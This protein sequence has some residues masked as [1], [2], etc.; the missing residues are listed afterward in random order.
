[1]GEINEKENSDFFAELN[2]E[3]TKNDEEECLSEFSDISDVSENDSDYIQEKEYDS[4]DSRY[5]SLEEEEEAD[6]L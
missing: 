5:E 2:N 1:M 4:D 6:D 3:N